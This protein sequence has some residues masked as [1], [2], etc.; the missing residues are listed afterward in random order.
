MLVDRHC[1]LNFP[2]LVEDVP[3]VVARA[4][5]AG[6]RVMV[7]ISVRVQELPTLIGYTEAY[8]GVFCSVGTHP[9]NAGE[10]REMEVCMTQCVCMSELCCTACTA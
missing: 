3:G 7:S 5:A 4:Q 2:R 9:H 8:D 6:V 10:P 1:H